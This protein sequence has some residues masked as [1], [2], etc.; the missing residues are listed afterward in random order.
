MRGMKTFESL[1]VGLLESQQDTVTKPR[2]ARHKLLW[3]GLCG[4]SYPNGF[5]TAPSLRC[6]PA[7][8]LG[9][10]LFVVDAPPIISQGSL[11]LATLGW[12]T[13]SRWDSNAP[14]LV[15]FRF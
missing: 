7:E 2:V 4:G 1:S 13:E 15:S 6:L 12:R 14:F 5:A 10:N 11:C 9:R 3:V 8:R